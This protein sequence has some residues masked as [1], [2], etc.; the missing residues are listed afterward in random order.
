MSNSLPPL[1]TFAIYEPRLELANER[2]FVIVKGGQ[3]VTYYPFGATSFSQNQF[4]FITNPPSKITVLDRVALIKVPLTITFT[5]T[6]PANVDNILQPGR[7]AFRAFPISS[8]TQTLTA[9]I[10]GFPVSI[11]LSEVIHCLSRFHMS[12]ELKNNFMS[13]LPQ[14]D[15]NYQN[16][17]DVD[18]GVNNPLGDYRDNSAQNPRGA[19]AYE[20]IVNTPNS[21]TITTTLYEYVFL[22]PFLFDGSEAGGLTHLDTLQFNWVL[23]NNVS[24]I[25]SHSTA[26]TSTITDINVTFTQPFMLLGFIT[27]RLTEPIPDLITYPYFQVSRFTTQS[28]KNILSNASDLLI[29]NVIQLNSI[30]RKMYLFAKQGNSVINSSLANTIQTTDTFLKINNVNIS[31]NNIDGV[32][33]GAS[34]PQLYDFSVQNGLRIT[35]DEWNGISQHLNAIAGQ[36]TEIFGLTGSVICIEF[37]KDIGLRDDEAEGMLGQYNLQVKLGVTN[38]NQTVTLQPDLYIICVFDGVLTITNNSAFGQ[39]GVISKQDVLTAPVRYDI[40]YNMLEKVYGGGNFFSKFRDVLSN[41][42]KGIQKYAPGVLSAAK[43]ISP[44]V[45]T[46][47]PV[48]SPFLSAIGLGEGARAGG[49]RA[50]AIAGDGAMGG[51][52][53]CGMHRCMCANGEGEGDGDGGVLLGGRAISRKEL[54]RRM[55]R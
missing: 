38:V 36:P 4:N 32:L 46:L 11:E 6:G 24:R 31:W 53:H 5:N 52:H 21:A 37:G 42:G 7:D 44:V 12:N 43:A 25:W 18:G 47:F 1:N 9:T 34:T 16:Y 28:N 13:V 27:P 51:C 39:I 26:S 55:R 49:V 41:I 15:D 20:T 50:G 54:R 48:S 23:S 19:Y 10:N 30:P 40:S 35:W 45:K 22:P 33:S 3:T 2:S 8:I 17:A 29:S 14:M